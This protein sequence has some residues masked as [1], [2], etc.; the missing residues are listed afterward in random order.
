M[1][2]VRKRSIPNYEKKRK[3]SIRRNG[4]NR[5][6]EQIYHMKLSMIGHQKRRV[7]DG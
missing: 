1:K 2:G 6:V 7:Q 5:I 4:K 3:E